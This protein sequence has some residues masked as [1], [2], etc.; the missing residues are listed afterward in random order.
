LISPS[1]TS[2]SAVSLDVIA[3]SLENTNTDSLF[4]DITSNYSA[5]KLLNVW[6][7]SWSLSPFILP[8]LWKCY[9]LVHFFVLLLHNTICE[10]G[11][12]LSTHYFHL[13]KTCKMTSLTYRLIVNYLDTFKSSFQKK[14]NHEQYWNL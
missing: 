1:Q 7:V 3:R 12:I 6:V 9:Y 4:S 8:V 5:Y 14:V 10:Y 13:L 11:D 2:C